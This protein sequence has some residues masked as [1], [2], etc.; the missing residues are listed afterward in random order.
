MCKLIRGVN[1][2]KRQKICIFQWALFRASSWFKVGE[3]HKPDVGLCPQNQE[4]I[5]R[6]THVLMGFWCSNH[7]IQS[8]RWEQ[9]DNSTHT[10]SHCGAENPS[11]P[12]KAGSIHL[13]HSNGRRQVLLMEIRKQ[14]LSDPLSFGVIS[15][16]AA[17][18][19]GRRGSLGKQDERGSEWPAVNM[20][21][22]KCISRGGK[23][24]PLPTQK[25]PTASPLQG[26]CSKATR[27]LTPQL[28]QTFML[29]FCKKDKSRQWYPAS[30]KQK[31]IL[32]H[33]LK[34][35]E[36]VQVKLLWTAMP[37]LQI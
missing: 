31:G 34:S 1:F 11:Q 21:W 3:K 35:P 33:A 8:N 12:R 15:K 4:R 23:T 19:R 17:L 5:S 16:R 32:P 37:Y 6:V 2:H 10:R 26:K 29:K 14:E 22:Q 27:W 25:F 9:K 18:L 36:S 7:R 13:R 24:S 30:V 20:E 28:S